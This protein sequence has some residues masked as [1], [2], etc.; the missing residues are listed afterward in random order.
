MLFIFELLFSMSFAADK[1]H[2][3]LR[4]IHN[5]IARTSLRPGE[6][7]AEK[8]WHAINGPVNVVSMWTSMCRNT[9][10]FFDSFVIFRHYFTG[11][12]KVSCILATISD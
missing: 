5:Y 6:E 12:G 4:P 11:N 8:I 9:F 2:A 1:R 7:A 3:W 10:N